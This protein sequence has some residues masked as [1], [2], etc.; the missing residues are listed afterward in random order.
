MAGAVMKVFWPYITYDTVFDHT[1]AVTE[2][3]RTPARFETYCAGMY[4]YAK[5]VKFQNPR[6]P[7]R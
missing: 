2:L 5:S 3:G 7:R 1:R 4:R 6:R